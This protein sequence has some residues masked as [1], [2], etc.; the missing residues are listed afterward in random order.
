LVEG[1]LIFYG[2][3]SLCRE[4]VNDFVDAMEARGWS[5]SYDNIVNADC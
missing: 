5:G 3:S 1:D 4:V 2:N